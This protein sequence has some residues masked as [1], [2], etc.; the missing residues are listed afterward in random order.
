MR[1]GW[2][3]GATA[4]KSFLKATVHSSLSVGSFLVNFDFNVPVLKTTRL[5]L[6]V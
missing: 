5:L 3:L 4:F 1:K 2:A 6:L